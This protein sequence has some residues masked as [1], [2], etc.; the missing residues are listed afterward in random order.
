MPY[1]SNCYRNFIRSSRWQRL[2][3]RYLVTHPLCE[4]CQAQGRVTVAC[5]VHHRQRCH[6]DPVL[7]VSWDNLEA[8]CNACH[9]PVSN[10]ERRGYSK[11]IGA[12]GYAADPDH[13][14]N[15]LRRAPLRFGTDATKIGK[16]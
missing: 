3:A 12:D 10:D 16:T 14:S 6:D 13:P 15:R 5:E 11:A 2:R 4:R 1:K 7:Q 9:L 8:I